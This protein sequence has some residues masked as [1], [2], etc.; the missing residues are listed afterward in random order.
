MIF[1]TLDQWAR[2]AAPESRL[3]TAFKFL[4]ET[5][6]NTLPIGRTEIDGDHLY[7]LVQEYSTRPLEE[8]KWEAHRRYADVQYVQHG[9][10][11]MGFA[12]LAV[13]TADEYLP[14]K[15]FLSLS[16]EGNFVNVFAGAF[17][18]FFPQDAHMP[19]LCVKTPQPVRKVVLKLLL[20]P[21]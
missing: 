14:E 10:E 11:R 4:C 5:D 19:C 16:G 12:N 2:Y 6:L 8:G 7:A 15:D 9:Q 3:A 21:E 1:D 20:E 18:V 17:V 13:M